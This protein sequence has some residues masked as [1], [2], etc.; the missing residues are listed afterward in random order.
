MLAIIYSF[1]KYR[2]NTPEATGD[3]EDNAPNKSYYKL[4]PQPTAAPKIRT[5][6]P[7]PTEPAQSE[8][9][10]PK[11]TLQELLQQ[12]QPSAKP[13]Q[14]QTPKQTFAPT[15]RPT[16]APT[17]APTPQ[18]LNDFVILD[19]ETTGL[20]EDAEI[21]EIAII[22]NHGNVLFNSYIKP[23]QP[24]DENSVAVGIHGIT[25]ATVA[26]A[27]TWREAY[28]KILP[29]LLSK[30]V[31]IYNAQYDTRLINQT[32]AKY[33]LGN[34]HLN[35]HCAMLKYAEFYGEE[36]YYSGGYRWQSLAKAMQ[37]TG[38][39][40]KGK[41]HSALADCLAVFDILLYM[42][43]P[44]AAKAR[45][46]QA[47]Q[48]QWEQ[49]LGNIWFVLDVN[50]G[51]KLSTSHL[52]DIAIFNQQ[53]DCVFNSLVA[54]KSRI[55]PDSK[56]ITELKITTEQL[57][58][59]QSFD[60][61]YPLL[62]STLNNQKAFAFAA[63]KTMDTL[64]AACKKYALPPINVQLTDVERELYALAFQA[65]NGYNRV[66]AFEKLKIPYNANSFQSNANALAIYKSIIS[67]A[68]RI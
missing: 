50:F 32:N 9:I 65:S 38:N 26:N 43:D 37:Q 12:H 42:Q 24:I 34:V 28:P 33:G 23:S 46:R 3:I 36:N 8:P 1:I 58:E 63:K 17:P 48:E 47:R 15:A 68:K 64:N 21:V 31:V 40:F 18:K 5:S 41:A 19:T 59:Y 13:A 66:N 67:T 10:K 55:K 4:T 16:T 29:I 44:K 11:P 60:Q 6:A 56:A 45:Q 61:I 57:S 53:G 35:A 30:A 27:P 52:L 62:F 2:Q 20:D 22:D 51:C 7:K 25:N 54:P 49:Y 39:Q 14:A